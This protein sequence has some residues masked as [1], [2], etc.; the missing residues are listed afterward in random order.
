MTA[1][2]EA[3]PGHRVDDSTAMDRLASGEESALEELLECY[4]DALVDYAASLVGSLDDAQDVVQDAFVRLWDRRSEWQKGTEPRPI[5]FRIVRNL[6][7]DLLRG[8]NVRAKWAAAGN[9]GPVAADLVAAGELE[10]EELSHAIARAL[11]TLGERERE[12]VRLCRFHGMSRREV[13]KVTGLASQTVSNL[14]SAARMRLRRA[15]APH[16]EER[17]ARLFVIESLAEPGCESE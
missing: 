13:T 2:I 10:A 7:L 9:P 3:A 4:W 16:L 11:E 6:A 14:L 12:V 17:A 1:A 5:M 8:A 15:L